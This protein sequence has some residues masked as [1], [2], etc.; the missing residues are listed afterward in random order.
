LMVTV[1]DISR[2]AQVVEKNGDVVVILNKS[3]QE[4]AGIN[5]FHASSYGAISGVGAI[6]LNEGIKALLKEACDKNGVALEMEWEQ[7]PSFV[8]GYVEEKKKHPNADKLSVCRVNIGTETLQIVCG[9]PNVAEGQKVVVALV[10][11]VM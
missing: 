10:G 1:Q 2:D 6:E 5:V 3:N 8:V 9:A 4:I 7:R 11:A